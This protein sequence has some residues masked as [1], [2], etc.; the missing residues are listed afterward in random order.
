MDHDEASELLGAFVLDS[1]NEN[2]TK[3]LRVHL[4]TCVQCRD[5]IDRLDAVVGLI[6][7]SELEEAPAH[8]RDA[9][10]NAVGAIKPFERMLPPRPAEVPRARAALRAWLDDVGVDGE[11]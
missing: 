2:E 1:C 3:R 6:G 5:E 11:K 4:T 10:V 9:V 8:L 7:A